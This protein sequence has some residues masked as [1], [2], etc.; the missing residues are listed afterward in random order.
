ML[1][2]LALI[3]T[4]SQT[5]M[6]NAFI[7]NRNRSL[8]SFEQQTLQQFYFFHG[9]ADRLDKHEPTRFAKNYRL[10]DCLAEPLRITKNAFKVP[11]VAMP[12]LNL[13]LSKEA[14]A[15]LRG[16]PNIE[17]FPVVWEKAYTLEW[18]EG[19]ANLV[20]GLTEDTEEGFARWVA[21]IPNDKASM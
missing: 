12:L 16:A 5:K 14:S 6:P 10:G 13:I 9:H 20:G 8:A 18:R 11:G 17:F 7:V 15:A 4:G 3:E 21:R 1:A 19:N 2:M